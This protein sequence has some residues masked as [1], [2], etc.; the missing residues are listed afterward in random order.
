MAIIHQLL[1]GKGGVGKSVCASLLAQYLMQHGAT[2]QCFDADPV[3][4]TL[5]GYSALGVT[6]VPLLAD[7]VVAPRLFD[8]FVSTMLIP[9]AADVH[10]IV[11]NGASTFTPATTYYQDNCSFE[12]LQ[13]SGH[14]ILLHTVI[15]GGQAFLDTL[16]GLETLI[17]TFP[18][19]PLVVWLNA[20]DGPLEAQGRKLE[21]LELWHTA[22]SYVQA[23]VRIPSLTHATFGID[24][25]NHFARKQTFA[26][27][28]DDASLY[29]TERQRLKIFWKKLCDELDNSAL[30]EVGA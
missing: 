10:A 5:Y 1:Q 26:E 6:R 17:H 9:L 20:K 24:L 21:D 18:N 15:A 4:T 14:Q 30:L 7:G 2:V 27:A 11:D 28:L 12:M 22:Q 29:I 16:T 25:Q 8:P 19:I 3:N 23:V 13:E